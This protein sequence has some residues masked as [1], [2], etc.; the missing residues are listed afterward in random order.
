MMKDRNYEVNDELLKK[1][2]LELILHFVQIALKN[3]TSI[4]ESLN[5]VYNNICIIFLDT[6]YDEVKKK[7]KMVCC[8][9]A[10]I[11]I[12]KWKSFYKTKYCIV[13]CP[14]KMSP[15]A[16]K[17][18]DLK[19]LTIMTHDFLMFPVGR[20]I[21]VPKHTALNEEE[22]KMFVEH[23][24]IQPQELPELKIYDPVS[25]YYGFKLNDIIKIERPSWTVFRVV[26][27]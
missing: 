19:R 6:N 4:S 1:N 22:K 8:E 11:A 7:E 12:D 14:G 25:L 26:T 10:K 27:S 16:K 13:V 5:D 21:L 3:E 15:D 9:Q 17:E 20:H 23:R 24:K 18:F 2:D